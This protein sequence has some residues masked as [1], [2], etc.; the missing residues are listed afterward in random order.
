M[1]DNSAIGKGFLSWRPT[2]GIEHRNGDC[3]GFQTQLGF[4]LKRTLIIILE[5]NLEKVVLI[6]DLFRRQALV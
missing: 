6:Y 2:S 1:S 4:V 5:G 3:I